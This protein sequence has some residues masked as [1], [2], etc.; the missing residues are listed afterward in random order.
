MLSISVINIMNK[1][2]LK[3]KGF[4]S[5]YSYTSKSNIEVKQGINSKQ[6][7]PE[8]RNLGQN[9]WRNAIYVSLPDVYPAQLACAHISS[10]PA[11]DGEAHSEFHSLSSTNISYKCVQSGLTPEVPYVLVTLCCLKLTINSKHQKWFS[12]WIS[13]KSRL[14][15][16]GLQIKL[17]TNLPSIFLVHKFHLCL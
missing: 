5:T 12:V 15:L 7:E 8:V 17:K 4:I 16:K 14:P 9:L 2:K 3:K 11:R 13:L 6:E 1:N 10:P